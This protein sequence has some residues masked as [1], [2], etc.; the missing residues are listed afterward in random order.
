MHAIVHDD[1]QETLCSPS[2]V[3]AS[4]PYCLHRELSFLENRLVSRSLYPKLSMSNFGGI[5]PWAES[6]KGILRSKLDL[7]SA[8]LLMSCVFCGTGLDLDACQKRNSTII[9]NI[10]RNLLFILM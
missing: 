4:F 6:R 2:N 9:Y 3:L 10:L 5:V 1:D 7:N 8:I